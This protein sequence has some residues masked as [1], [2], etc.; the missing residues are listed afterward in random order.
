[1]I[2]VGE[3]LAQTNN[4]P[5]GFDYMRIILATSVILYHTIP[6][7]RGLAAQDVAF[8]SAFRPLIFSILPLF[9][10][11]SGFLVASSLERCASVITFL[12]LRALRIV[13][14][15][16]V[17][18]LFSAIVLGA[19]FTDLPLKDYFSSKKFF[20]YFLN[21]VGDIH[22]YLPGVFEKNPMT[23]A[24]GQLWTIP[25]EL[26]CYLFLAVVGVFKI[27]SKRSL[28]LLL[29]AGLMVVLFSRG[30]ISHAHWQVSEDIILIPSFA[31]GVAI[32]LYRDVLPWNKFVA[33]I[34]LI[35]GIFFLERRDAFMIFAAIPAAYLTVYLGL[36]DPRRIGLLKKGDYSY[37]LYLYGMPMQ[38]ALVA[39]LPL[40]KIWYVNFLLAFPISLCFAALSWHFFEK[41]ALGWRRVLTQ[42]ETWWLLQWRRV[43]GDRI[44]AKLPL[45]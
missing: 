8:N 41:P 20:D 15:L 12:G 35:A 3:R 22:Y 31:C 19:V 42:F 4:R 7:G 21:I 33:A 9:F 28:F 6:V 32:Y 39:T 44:A 36:L 14:A 13:P 40:A 24:N 43:F 30:F 1:M 11:L 26:K 38:Q 2:S 17:D 5:A 10:A 34:C 45:Q 37:G 27:Q 25:A 23:S 29:V 18:T 16:T